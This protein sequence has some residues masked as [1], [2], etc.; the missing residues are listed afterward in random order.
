MMNTR[1]LLSLLL[2]LSLLSNAFAQQTPKQPASQDDDVVKITT[3]LVQVDAIVTDK[4]GRVVTDLQ[5]SDFQVF[6]DGHPQ[7]ITNF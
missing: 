2:S 6:E 4:Q 5:A 1:T 7:P 3:N